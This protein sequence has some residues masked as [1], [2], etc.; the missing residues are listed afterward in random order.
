ML[1]WLAHLL[2][3]VPHFVIIFLFTRSVGAVPISSWNSCVCYLSCIV[4]EAVL[5]LWWLLCFTV[6]VTSTEDGN[7]YSPK[8][9][10]A[11]CVVTM[12]QI[13][14]Y[15]LNTTTYMKPCHKSIQFTTDTVFAVNPLNAELN[16]IC[17]L[18]ALLELTI[19]ST[20]SG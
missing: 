20:L 16:P 8:R 15:N 4:T 6:S 10:V 13:V 1:T 18:L 2:L 14:T 19:F 17:Y 9:R 11:L 3:H 5:I 7:R 12:Q